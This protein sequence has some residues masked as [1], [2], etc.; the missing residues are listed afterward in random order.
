[1]RSFFPSPEPKALI[2]VTLLSRILRELAAPQIE[3]HQWTSQ[4]DSCDICTFPSTFR[5]IMGWYDG[6]GCRPL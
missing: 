3:Y 5:S 1:M 4:S 6:I 2:C